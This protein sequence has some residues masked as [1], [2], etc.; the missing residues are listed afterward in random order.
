MS[1]GRT[2]LLYE[3][4]VATTRRPVDPKAATQSSVRVLGHQS[5]VNEPPQR[6]HPS[7]PRGKTTGDTFMSFSPSQIGGTKPAT[8]QARA[9]TQSRAPDKARAQTQSNAPDQRKSE[10]SFDFSPDK[11]KHT[12]Q[13][14]HDQPPRGSGHKSGLHVRVAKSK[15]GWDAHTVLG[16]I[17]ARR[18]EVN[19]RDTMR[20][21]KL[22]TVK[23]PEGV[24]YQRLL[25]SG[26]PKATGNKYMLPHDMPGTDHKDP[27]V[28]SRAWRMQAQAQANTLGDSYT[29]N[30]P[31]K[32]E[33]R[34]K[35]PV[36]VH[37]VRH[38]PTG[39]METRTTFHG[40]ERQDFG[41]DYEVVHTAI[42]ESLTRRALIFEA[43]PT[44]F[45]T[46]QPA[47]HG[48]RT[49][50]ARMNA[51]MQAGNQQ[52]ADSLKKQLD[53]RAKLRQDLG[54]ARDTP[55][56]G[57]VTISTNTQREALGTVKQHYRGAKTQELRPPS[58]KTQVMST[59]PSGT[60]GGETRSSLPTPPKP[61]ND[62]PDQKRGGTRVLPR[63]SIVSSLLDRA[64]LLQELV[65]AASAGGNPGGA[66]ASGLK[67]KDP[68]VSSTPRD[69]RNLPATSRKG[70]AVTTRDVG[71]T[72]N[73]GA[74]VPDKKQREIKIPGPKP[75][76]SGYRSIERD[77]EDQPANVGGV[78]TLVRDRP[79]LLGG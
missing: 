45:F 61:L 66:F 75:I 21:G 1:L 30:A 14:E 43:H 52:L 67:P 39:R 15:D 48:D 42:S 18:H 65:T 11:E 64:P 60:P 62:R 74:W 58:H 31:K 23:S 3:A 50:Q 28:R 37:V 36:Q 79:K 22:Q 73:T 13:G 47:V 41:K 38:R 49:V 10:I 12:I 68:I 5:D 19:P 20:S 27:S 71:H 7:T 77:F 56:S 17:H 46:K 26:K 70:G 63:Q 29:G 54:G 35:A 24:S 25:P 72:A 32:G 53:M 8:D 40:K 6:S 2:Q 9:Q 44:A 33:R 55:E 57:A 59:P 78:L 76:G 34:S 51:A 69:Q 4:P 16:Q